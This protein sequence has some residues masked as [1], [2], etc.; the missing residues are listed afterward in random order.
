VFCD[1]S[2]SGQPPSPPLVETE[3]EKELR[4][5]LKQANDTAARLRDELRQ[6]ADRQTSLQNQLD[7]MKLETKY[8]G[9]KITGLWMQC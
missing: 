9:D 7:K 4:Q 8:R 1:R 6:A 3:Q 5:Q 2:I